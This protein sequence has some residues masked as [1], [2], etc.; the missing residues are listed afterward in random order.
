M[1]LLANL[2]TYGSSWE[3]VSREM[4]S[5]D[6]EFKNIESAEVQSKEQE[7]GT[8]RSICL[9]MKGGGTKYLALSR[10]SELEDGDKVDPASIEVIELERDGDTIYRADGEVLKAKKGRGK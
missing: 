6:E 7:W 4:L 1:G 5:E 8:S 9:F 2:T 10:D 3:E